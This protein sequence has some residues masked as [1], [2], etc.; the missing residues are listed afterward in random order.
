MPLSWTSAT[1]V[2]RHLKTA[3]A[4][5]FGRTCSR[6][7]SLALSSPRGNERPKARRE[8]A[9]PPLLVCEAGELPQHAT[10]GAA[11]RTKHDRRGDGRDWCA[12][13]ARWIAGGLRCR[14]FAERRKPRGVSPAGAG[15]SLR[16]L[17]QSGGAGRRGR[18][19]AEKAKSLDGWA[20]LATR[21]FVGPP[22]KSPRLPR[23]HC[24]QRR[25]DLHPL[26]A[27]RHQWRKV[28]HPFHTSAAKGNSF[29]SARA[30]RHVG[31]CF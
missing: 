17:Q 13:R 3:E 6:K 20:R 21:G 31:Y 9:S 8:A 16:L 27:H 19:G 15:Q 4:S 7:A 1:S 22:L 30:S 26:H 11:C 25:H 14:S 10:G 5:F 12:W 18:C 2:N 29:S 28:S 23:V 24:R